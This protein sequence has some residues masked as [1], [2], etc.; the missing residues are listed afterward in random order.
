M[1]SEIKYDAFISYRHCEP[2]GFVAKKLHEM[3]ESYKPPKKLKK[4]LP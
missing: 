3:L 1:G 4:M 2:D